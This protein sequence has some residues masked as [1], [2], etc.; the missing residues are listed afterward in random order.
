MANKIKKWFIE[1]LELG[2][3]FAKKSELQV[4][5]LDQKKYEFLKKLELWIF[6]L[7]KKVSIH[8]FW[9]KTDYQVKKLFVTV[10]E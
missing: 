2:I 8:E 6:S 10:W 7:K 5:H 1:I 9:L 3:N 4:L